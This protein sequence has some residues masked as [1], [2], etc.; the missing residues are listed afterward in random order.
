MGKQH[1]YIQTNLLDE[2][3]ALSH[4]SMPR[5]IILKADC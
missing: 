3:H 2:Q 5:Q 4:I 1:T